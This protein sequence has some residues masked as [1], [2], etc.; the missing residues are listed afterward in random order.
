[1]IADLR[2]IFKENGWYYSKSESVIGISDYE[3]KNLMKLN[4]IIKIKAG[5]YHWIDDHFEDYVDLAH[6]SKIEPRGVFCLYTAMY[7]HNLTTFIA[8]KYFLAMPR[9]TRTS[10]GIENYSIEIKKWSNQFF[11]LGIDMKKVGNIL[12]RMYNL[13]K[14]V[15]DAVRFRKDIGQD[16]LKEVIISYFQSPQKNYGKLMKYAEILHVKKI[17]SN[18]CSMLV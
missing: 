15:C 16:L 11:D 10:T 12:I 18:Y 3:L 13:E 17:L 8:P 1:M 7:Y 9:N 4:K 14:T 5:L 2:S 6:I